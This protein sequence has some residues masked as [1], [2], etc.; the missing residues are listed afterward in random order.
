MILDGIRIL[1]F[2]TGIAGPNAGRILASLGAEVIKVES[3]SGGVDAFRYFGVG[4]DLNS[5][6][7]FA[8]ANLGVRSLT[9]D[10]KQPDGIALI[11][12]LAGLCDVVLENYRPGVLDRLGLGYPALKAIRPD[13]I[14]VK[15]PG[16]GST[17]PMRGYGTWGALLNAYSGLTWLWNHAG[18]TT[19][20]GNQG[21]FPDYLSAVLA[22]MVVVSALINRQTTGL[23]SVI[24]LAQS[25]ATAFCA[26]PQAMLHVSVNGSDPEPIGNRSRD[27]AVQ[28][29]Y[30]CA[31]VDR[32]CAIRV[33]SNEQ[34]AELLAVIA[35]DAAPDGAH[36]PADLDAAITGHDAL[37]QRIAGWTR[38]RS[39]EA[40]MAALQSRGVSAGTVASGADLLV[41]PQLDRAG[42]IRHLVQPGIG[43][44]VIPGLPMEVDPPIIH[45]PGPAA[46]LG[47]DNDYVL[48]TLLSLSEE[49]CVALAEA[50]VLV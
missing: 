12:R 17:G 16:L 34:L 33:E 41:D 36:M 22:P 11:Q 27:R 29:V 30:P 4:D 47:Q 1:S 24:D 21:V 43:E 7:R 28:G 23:G 26:L 32:W 40:V 3:R 37:D 14:V 18:A 13:I 42:F 45:E 49:E 6:A 19:P 20:V 39:P 5:S 9:V 50:G 46:A 35:E 48:R 10:L 15:M 8:E 31:G 2:T 44:M 38:E 25:E